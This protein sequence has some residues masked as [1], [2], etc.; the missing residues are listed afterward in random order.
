MFLILLLGIYPIIK[1][2]KKRDFVIIPVKIILSFYLN[3]LIYYIQKNSSEFNQFSSTLI[4]IGN[5]NAFFLNW[6]KIENFKLDVLI[7]IISQ[8]PFLVYKN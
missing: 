5:L 1:Y 8:V 4:F 6:L 3:F 2:K 7:V